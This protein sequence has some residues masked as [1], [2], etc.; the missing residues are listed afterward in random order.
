MRCA[1]SSAFPPER[2]RG[3][4][5]R[6]RIWSGVGN[7]RL[8]RLAARG[9]RRA[10]LPAAVAGFLLLAGCSTPLPRKRT[11]IGQ[12]QTIREE[13]E[14][15]GLN[16]LGT[17]ETCENGTGAW[18]DGQRVVVS[19]PEYFTE[20]A[21]LMILALREA[22]GENEKEL[23]DLDLL[24]SRHPI[25]D[26][27]QA[28]AVGRQCGALIVLWERR[29]SQTLELTLPHPARVP[30]RA[31][32]QKNLCEF[33]AHEEQAAVLYLTILGLTAM[34]KND[35]DLASYYLNSA[36]GIDVECL[37]LP[38]GRKPVGN[39]PTGTQGPAPQM[40]RP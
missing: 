34:T 3:R 10:G 7:A 27:E 17:L 9:L 36:K 13:V 33:G 12:A 1:E 16:P 11:F 35:Y 24:L 4:P 20:S 14:P 5:V 29:E 22:L 15:E 32:V 21:S 25:A 8:L 19:R 38:R 31:L 23:K 18:A 6:E 39:A 37:Q 2:Q 30:L 28:R 40:K 26:V